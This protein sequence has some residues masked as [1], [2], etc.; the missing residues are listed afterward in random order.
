MKKNEKEISRFLVLVYF[1]KFDLFVFVLLSINDQSFLNDNLFF[2]IFL[3]V[4]ISLFRSSL[5]KSS[6][7]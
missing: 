2:F 1:R 6:V 5:I 4:S 7:Y 3:Y